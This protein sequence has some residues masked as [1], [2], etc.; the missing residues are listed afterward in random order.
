[1]LGLSYLL[2]CKTRITR[3][4]WGMGGGA[5]FCMLEDHP[6][7]NCWQKMYIK[8]QLNNNVKHY[9][10]AYNFCF[11][12]QYVIVPNNDWSPVRGQTI[13]RNNGGSLDNFFIKFKWNFLR[14]IHFSFKKIHL[15]MSSAKWWPCCLGLNISKKDIKS[16]D[17]MRW[18]TYHQAPL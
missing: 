3:C 17:V 9:F 16:I 14:N 11:E 8:N 5:S 15:K 13:I 2:Y 18:Q 12:Q 1:M 10:H 4:L 7:V 6:S